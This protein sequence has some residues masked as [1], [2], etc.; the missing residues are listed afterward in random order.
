M[1][2]SLTLVK[3][4]VTAYVEDD[5]HVT[6]PSKASV[7]SCGCDRNHALGRVQAFEAASG[8]I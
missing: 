5:Q 3:I 8:K 4:S 6:Q 2:L 7:V 1:E